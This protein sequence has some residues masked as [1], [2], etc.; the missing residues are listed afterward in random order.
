[1]S[2]WKIARKGTACDT[3][4]KVFAPGETFV[5]AIW[6]D[7]DAQFKRRDLHPACFEAVE[8]EAYS[9]WVTA[10]PEKKE[11]KPPWDVAGAEAA[12]IEPLLIV[13]EESY[14]KGTNVIR[15]LNELPDLLR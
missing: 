11:K 4:E 5:S 10:I 9:R 2:D 14:S 8:A 12:G 7:E 15:S 6:L 1:M 13:R 3:C